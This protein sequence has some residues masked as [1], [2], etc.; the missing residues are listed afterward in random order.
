MGIRDLQQKKRTRTLRG[1]AF[2][3][4]IC[5][6]GSYFLTEL[7]VYEDGLID[8]WG[9]VDQKLFQQK[10][11]SGWVVTEVPEHESLHIHGVG[12]FEVLRAEWQHSPQSLAS[13]VEDVIDT[14]NPTRVNLFDLR[15]KKYLSIKG[16]RIAISEFGSRP[17]ETWKYEDPEWPISG[18]V[19]GRTIRHFF[20]SDDV[21]RL[22]TI[23]VFGDETVR[24]LG[25]REPIEKSFEELASDFSSRD[26]FRI[27]ATGDHVIVDQIGAFTCGKVFAFASEIDLRNEIVDIHKT[28]SGKGSSVVLCKRAFEEY[29]ADPTRKTREELRKAYESVPRHMRHF[30]GDQDS[31]DIPIRMILYGKNQIEHWSHYLVAKHLGQELPTIHVP[32]PK[33]ER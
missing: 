3:G 12:V 22:V 21:L 2:P 9:L 14:L 10:L 6:G 1:V 15:D 5:N 17:R 23:K 29:C 16:A 13:Y 26:R 25:M 18:T 27:P 11:D 4:I 33:D 31:K 28:V 20:Q 8:C 30:C 32:E 7:E 19:I 24:I